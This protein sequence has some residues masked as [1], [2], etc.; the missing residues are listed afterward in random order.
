MVAILVVHSDD[1]VVSW[2]RTAMEVAG[3][4]VVE[5]GDVPMTQDLDSLGVPMLVLLRLVPPHRDNCCDG[6]RISPGVEAGGEVP[7]VIADELSTQTIGDSPPVELI[8]VRADRQGDRELDV[9][10]RTTVRKAIRRSVRQG[11]LTQ[12][13]ADWLLAAL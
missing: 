12:E 1:N 5:A 3:L 6:D 10:N 8:G 9:D 2:L 11:S 4:R 7:S 13:Q